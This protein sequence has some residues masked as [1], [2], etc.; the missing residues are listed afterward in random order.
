M[1]RLAPAALLSAGAGACLT[2]LVVQHHPLQPGSPAMTHA[3]FTA[4]HVERTAVIDLPVP[5]ARAFPLFTPE[6]ERL[7]AEGWDPE[8]LYPGA[9]DSRREGIFRTDAHGE[10]TVWLIL[11]CDAAEGRAEYAVIAPSTRAGVVAVHCRALGSD[12]TR[13]EVSYRMTALS[14]TGNAH[15]A[16][17]AAHYDEIIGG[18]RPHLLAALARPSGD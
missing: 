8:V 10:R 3:P 15:L 12:S 2:L 7:W 9:P 4:T 14:A 18:W 6:G 13:V 11:G 5:P 1:M 16:H 17:F